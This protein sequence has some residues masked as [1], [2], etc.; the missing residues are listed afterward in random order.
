RKTT[1]KKITQ[2]IPEKISN[3]LSPPTVQFSPKQKLTLPNEPLPQRFQNIQP[4]ATKREIELG[5]L[6]KIIEDPYVQSIECDGP[7]KQIKVL[8]KRGKSLT[9]T[10]LTKEEI[11][12]IIQ[13][14]S[15]ITRIPIMEGVYKVAAGN[16]IL[17][18]VISEVIGTKFVI[19]KINRQEQQRQMPPR[20]RRM[21]T[22][23]PRM[24]QLTRR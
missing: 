9:N 13:T 5:K 19:R 14:F 3:K 11:D 21:N 15:E 23:P 10:Q 4:T 20:M 1:Q 18:A 24:R 22:R 2:K 12:K 17:L 8:S 6:N 7:N 16:L